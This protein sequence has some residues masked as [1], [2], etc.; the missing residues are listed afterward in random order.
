MAPPLGYAAA[1]NANYLLPFV[2]KA[3]RVIYLCMS[4][5]VS[6]FESFDYKPL[7]RKHHNKPIPD[8]L[9]EGQQLAQLQDQALLCFEPQT[10]FSRHGASGQQISDLFPH[11][12]SISD[13]IAIINS[14]VTE[15]INHDPAMTLLNTGTFMAGRPSVGAW[16]DYAIG[17][18]TN[19][20]PGYIVFDS[21]AAGFVQPLHGRLWHS[22]F[23]PSVHQGIKLNSRGEAV[24][25][26][27]TP[28]GVSSDSQR[29][30][31]E[32]V[33]A[34]NNAYL[35]E[36]GDPEA[37]TRNRQYDM[38]LRMQASVPDLMDLSDESE[39]TFARYGC[40]PGDG[41]F[42]YNCL[43]ARRLA[44]QNV[45]CIQLF[46][47]AWDHHG[48]IKAN[49]NIA[50]RS[51]DQ[52]TAALILDLEQ[53]GMLDDTLVVWGTEFGRT[54]MS[55]GGT[56]RDHHMKAF[57]FFMAGAGI[58]GGVTHGKTDPF[59]YNVIENPVHVRDMNA[60]IL[61]L[62]GIDHAKLTYRFQ[63]LDNRLTGVESAHIVNEILS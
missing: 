26:V 57:S 39:E 37:I 2:P 56:G 49:M 59:G 34:L 10:T 60:T 3:R 32:T 11:I 55:Q 61:H 12:A 1:Q 17:A 22:G 9:T 25:Y 36:T 23:L 19:K 54:P 29:Q 53:R 63:G 46:H 42:A 52:A 38:A 5:G 20:L 44:E 27:T 35:K 7:L 51:V 48:D 43:L 14:A 16:I 18:E 8:S 21:T 15:Q 6:Q 45:R 4:G 31:V 47:R 62:M 24:Y 30:T 41:S 40:R 58:K 33:K 50:A 13:R 28:K